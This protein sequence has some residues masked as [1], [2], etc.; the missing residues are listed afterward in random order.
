[1][2][3]VFNI[4]LAVMMTFVLAFSLTACKTPDDGG[5]GDKGLL[6][7]KIGEVYTI[8]DFVDDG[9]LVDGKL[10]IGAILAEKELDNVT[11]KKGAFDGVDTVST[12]IVSDRVTEIEEGA[13][14]KMQNL[15]ELE[16][17]FIG[18][19][20]MADARFN[21]TDAQVNKS[22]GKERTIAH[23][24]GTESYDGGAEIT[25]AYG[26]V[27]LPVTLTTLTINA[28]SNV[29]YESGDKTGYAIPY[30]AFQGATNLTQITL[31]GA[32][33]FEIGEGAFGDCTHLTSI[34]IPETVKTIYKDAFLGC[35]AMSKVNSADAMTVDFVNIT[36]EI[37]EGAF[38]F[39]KEN[40][41]YNVKNAGAY[42][43]Q[44]QL[45]FGDTEFIKVN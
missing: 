17:P 38:D 20:A 10:D 25:S 15:V 21:Q 34:I 6:I 22:T 36:A 45:I 28:T 26:K 44:L 43:S 2:R 27:Y 39:R 14:R 8:Y 16:L 29:K 31:T 23:L 5:N 18:K 41:K 7:K 35:T 11:I 4:L 13:F 30:Q 32:N 19:N 1:M 3:K 42:E 37:E 9:T 12:L 33:L 40:A 24:F